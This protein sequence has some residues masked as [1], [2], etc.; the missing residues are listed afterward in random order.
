MDAELWDYSKKISLMHPAVV[1]NSKD[2]VII[3]YKL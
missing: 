2:K 1:N 3:M